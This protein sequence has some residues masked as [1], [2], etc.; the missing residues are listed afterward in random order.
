MDEDKTV[1]QQIED[2]VVRFVNDYLQVTPK[3]VSIDIHAGDIVAALRGV[4][5]PVE[6]D[7]AEGNPEGRALLEKCYSDTFDAAKECL[8]QMIGNILGR[9]IESSM[10]RI[11]PGPGSAVLIFSLADG[12]EH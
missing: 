10:L 7:L 9:A 11:A 1:K 4:V 5:P 12:P 2:A 8:E 3:S 6:R